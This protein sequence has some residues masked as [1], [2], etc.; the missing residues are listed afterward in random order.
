METP[1]WFL[2]SLMSA[3][4]SVAVANRR[5]GRST[6]FMNVGG[7]VNGRVSSGESLRELC[8]TRLMPCAV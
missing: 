1:S 7:G 4:D 5:G 6:W 3:S 2:V 8:R